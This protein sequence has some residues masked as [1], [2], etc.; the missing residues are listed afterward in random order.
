M[1]CFALSKVGVYPSTRAQQ[2]Q[3][4]VLLHVID[5]VKIGRQI[6]KAHAHMQSSEVLINFTK[7]KSFITVFLYAL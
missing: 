2:P 6:E 5:Q 3:L 7:K 4:H 1:W